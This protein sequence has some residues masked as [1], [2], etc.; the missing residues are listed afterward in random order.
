MTMRAPVAAAVGGAI[1]ALVG[2]VGD[3]DAASI[4]RLAVTGAALAA[5][6][7]SDL[8]DRRIPN[9]VTVPAALALL[10]LWVATGASLEPVAAGLGV[11]AVLLLI[12]VA[13]PAVIGMGDGKLGV[14]V[15]LGLS[16]EALLGLASGI[17]LAAI[18]GAVQLARSS[19]SRSSAVPLAPFF[20]LGALVV[21][22]A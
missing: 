4:V 13:W 9:G 19:N 22:V 11:A 17:I 2:S 10:A 20:A 5:A 7:V 12:G 18:F 3:F 21:L 8:V 16:D 14:V 15:A 1:F 6:A